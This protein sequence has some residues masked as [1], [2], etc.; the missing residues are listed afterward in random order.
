MGGW[1]DRVYLKPERGVEHMCVCRHDRTQEGR[2]LQTGNAKSQA[3]RAPYS[4]AHSA[5]PL[6]LDALLLLVRGHAVP[7]LEDAV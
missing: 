5:Q 7:Q 2:R 1:T 4:P 3:G 6:Q